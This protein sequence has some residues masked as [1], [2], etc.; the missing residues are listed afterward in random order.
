MQVY[1]SVCCLDLLRFPRNL[2]G[3]Y[4]A[5]SRSRG[6]IGKSI[7]DVLHSKWRNIIDP[8]FIKHFLKLLF[9]NDN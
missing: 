3:E 1:K 6:M 4:L 7:I 2:W 9:N 5:S 8:Q